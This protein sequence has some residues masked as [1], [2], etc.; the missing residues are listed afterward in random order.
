MAKLE[1]VVF[2]EVFENDL[3]IIK[4]RG[5][6]TGHTQFGEISFSSN[7]LKRKFKHAE[8][9]GIDTVKNNPNNQL[10]YYNAVIAHLNDENTK[11]FGVYRGNNQQKVYYNKHTGIAVII[12]DEI[13]FL[14]CFIPKDDT[15]PQ[16][17]NYLNNGSLW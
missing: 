16:L 7:A 15:K 11:Q 10:S 1:P 17:T 3:S 14:T 5:T 8:V 9:F 6:L 4:K 12:D 13:G 2:R